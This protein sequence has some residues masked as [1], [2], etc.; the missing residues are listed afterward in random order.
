[1]RILR[2][3]LRRELFK[4]PGRVI[5]LFLIVFLGAGFFSG[6]RSSAP[7]M[8]RTADSYF[9][10][11]RL[12]DYRLICDMGITADDVS[13]ARALPGILAASPA[14]AVD[15]TANINGK[16]F[17]LAVRSYEEGNVITE[18]GDTL[19]ADVSGMP[20]GDAAADPSANAISRLTLTE[21]RI[22][23]APNECLADPN[24]ALNVGNVVTIEEGNAPASLNRLAQREFL[25]VGRALS[26]T[27]ISADRGIASVGNGR[28]YA[29]LFVPEQSFNTDYYSELNI[30]LAS[31]QGLSAFSSA[32]QEALDDAVPMLEAFTA[33]RSEARFQALWQDVKSDLDEAEAQFAQN[34]LM[35]NTELANAL[36]DINSG[37]MDIT[38]G[39]QTYANNMGKL[40]AAKAQI[41]AKEIELKTSFDTI[42][43]AKNELSHSKSL[44]AGNQMALT[45]LYQQRATLIANQ[46]AETDPAAIAALQNQIDVLSGQIASLQAQVN[47]ASVALATAEKQ[48]QDSEMTYL[49]GKNLFEAAR[50]E[51]ANNEAALK[52]FRRELDLAN[53][54]LEAG[55]R[56]Y[57]DKSHAVNTSISQ[58]RD[59]LD[60]NQKRLSEMPRPVWFSQNRVDLPGYTGFTDD[61]NRIDRLSMIVPW[62]FFLVAI[63]VCL[64][65][66]TRMVEEH[67]GMIGTLKALGYHRDDISRSYQLFAW[68]IGL[69]GG[70][71]GVYA[72]LFIFPRAVW[73][74]Y[75]N[76]YYM[77]SEAFS[78]AP[79][80]ISCAIG[81]FGGAATV[82]IATSMACQRTLYSSVRSLM[83]PKAP[84]P[85]K[86]LLIERAGF[87]WRAFSFKTKVTLRNLFRYKKRL[88][89]TILGVGGCTAILLIG[90]GLRDSINSM[91]D[92]QYE[93]I[94]HYDA[95]IFLE[96]PSIAEVDTELNRAL[97]GVD[98]AYVYNSAIKVTSGDYDNSKIITL[99][100]VPQ[101]PDSL[102][103]FISF[104]DSRT[105]TEIPFPVNDTDGPAAIITDRLAKELH[106]KEGDY[107][108][109]SESGR[110]PAP[111][112]VAGVT[113][114]Y[115]YNYVYI[116]PETYAAFYG[117]APLY[118][119]VI[120][121][122]DMQN[123][124]LNDFLSQIIAINGVGSA[125]SVAR[126]QETVD[127]IV[128]NIS[129][130]V[131]IMIV[132]AAIL[133]LVV[134]YNMSNI[135]I[136]ERERELATL[137]VVGYYRSEVSAYISRES[138]VLAII[139]IAIGLFFGIYIHGFVMDSIA[140]NDVMFA[141][142]I[143]WQSFVYASGFTFL[144]GI[145]INIGM[146][147]RLRRIDPSTALKAIE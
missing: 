104:K 60:A 28:V 31:T 61:A 84:I 99:L 51:Y 24:S 12:A 132:V 127:G 75:G 123:Q 112:R 78:L 55:I 74:A 131:W 136:T 45:Q 48:I 86:R 101:H 114:N 6:F 49:E 68:I 118:S 105:G 82:G 141:H 46:A 2:K 134:L 23:A 140:V 36:S 73:N 64:T 92:V 100:Y 137:K 20:S 25:V 98:S 70:G 65:T 10:Q 14:C 130:I 35:A 13:A 71:A 29:Y 80:P 110:V 126:L 67:R 147:P 76:M 109:F 93:E 37:R 125:I 19:Q 50:Q 11:T 87:L 97:A 59:E 16:S 91:M 38:Q 90:F 138:T 89:T 113:E 81:L 139:G 117:N 120:I 128:E 34:S 42:T 96:Q 54:R 122:P 108:S 7:S 69:L 142:V 33:E 39:E 116:S 27:Y 103:R 107:I 17:V 115:I 79:G 56:A 26:P 9:D 15:L 43:N 95:S 18:S 133:A 83:R 30:R 53:V 57:Y 40:P 58:A 52:G 85:G 111:V 44:L 5:A 1:M 32:Y 121:D 21:G 63:L 94:S 72:G 88:F 8:E 41:D 144:C 129:T 47:T 119:T 102:N 143:N 62:F 124:A 4:N 22:P 146:R 3:T 77:G 135:N 106:V 145:L 66:M